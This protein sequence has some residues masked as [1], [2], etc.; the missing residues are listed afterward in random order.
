MLVRLFDFEVLTLDLTA[1]NQPTYTD[2]LPVPVPSSVLTV[3]PNH[4]SSTPMA[5][6]KLVAQKSVGGKA[7]RR[8]IASQPKQSFPSVFPGAKKP[9]RYM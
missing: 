8:Q 2:L 7:P 5:R 4:F 6:K 3:Y 9:H 1:Y